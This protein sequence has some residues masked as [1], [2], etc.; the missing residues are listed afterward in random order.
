M[1]AAEQL[2][3]LCRRYFPGIPGMQNTTRSP[4][5]CLC[6]RGVKGA[7]MQFIPKLVPAKPLGKETTAMTLTKLLRIYDRSSA[8]MCT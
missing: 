5:G 4:D 6:T 8:G 1:R 7:R 2:W 3:K